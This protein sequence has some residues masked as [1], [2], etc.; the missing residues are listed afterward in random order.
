VYGILLGEKP[1]IK[2]FLLPQP[3]NCGGESPAMHSNA[4]Y[5]VYD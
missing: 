2:P 5:V 1:A 3:H 4:P